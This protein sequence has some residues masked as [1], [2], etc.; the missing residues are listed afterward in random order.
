[1]RPSTEEF[2]GEGDREEDVDGVTE[3]WGYI[4]EWYRVEEVKGG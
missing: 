3:G 1:L 2:G 4:V